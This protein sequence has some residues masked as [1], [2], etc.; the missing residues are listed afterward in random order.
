LVAL[1]PPSVTA[2]HIV[3]PGQI[4]SATRPDTA[5]SSNLVRHHRHNN[6]GNKLSNAKMITRT[7]S[8]KKPM[9]LL[10][11]P[12]RRSCAL[13]YKAT[14]AKMQTKQNTAI[15][16][17]FGVDIGRNQLQ[18]RTIAPAVPYAPD[19]RIFKMRSMMPNDQS[20]ATADSRR[21]PRQRN[22]QRQRRLGL[23]LGITQRTITAVFDHSKDR[24]SPRKLIPVNVKT[25]GDRLL[26]KRI[27][28]DFSQSEVAQKT[29]VSLRTVW[30]WEHGI[31]CPS[32]DHWQTLKQILRLEDVFPAE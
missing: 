19:L 6:N 28:A 26:M 20:W 32:E 1:V 18:T 16:Y 21:E 29:R 17:E 24:Y 9:L 7:A 4:Q 12:D 8:V 25:L 5:F 11:S 13:K 22:W 15:A 10:A 3:F 2:R 27:E 23:L 31:A 30:K 14:P